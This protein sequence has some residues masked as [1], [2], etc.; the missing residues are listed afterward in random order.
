VRDYPRLPAN[1][2]AEVEEDTAD[3]EATTEAPTEACTGSCC[4]HS[5]R[6][7]FA[8]IGYDWIIS[9]KQY[10]ANYCLGECARPTSVEL[11][12]IHAHLT[13]PSNVTRCCAPKD[14]AGLQVMYR[15]KDGGF[16]KRVI[17]RMIVLSCGCH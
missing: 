10:D 15:D 5:F 7:D 12:S 11:S 17:D 16:H 6:V 4:R 9:P 8:S 14:M 1:N 13:I 3:D 2:A